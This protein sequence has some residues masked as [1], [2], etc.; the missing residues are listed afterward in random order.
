MTSRVALS[1]AVIVAVGLGMIPRGEVGLIFAQIGRS[2]RIGE[3]HQHVDTL[4]M[5]DPLSPLVPAALFG[6]AW[7]GVSYAPI[8]YR[9]PDD[10]MQELLRRLDID[11]PVNAFYEIRP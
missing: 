11:H 1:I 5:I 9:L 8:N 4:A 7:A 2:L 3:E 10:Q 6:A